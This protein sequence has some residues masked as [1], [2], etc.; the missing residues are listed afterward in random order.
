MIDMSPEIIK[1]TECCYCKTHFVDGSWLTVCPD[2]EDKLYR[3]IIIKE[4]QEKIEKLKK[5]NKN[6][7][8][9]RHVTLHKIAE[10]IER[11]L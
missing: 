6:C 3:D 7:R 11:L 9:E 5:I 2:C 10:D 1:L 8:D 4:L